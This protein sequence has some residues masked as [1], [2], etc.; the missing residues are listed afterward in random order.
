MARPGSRHGGPHRALARRPPAA[1]RT[2]P[3]CSG[4][5]TDLAV[6]T[7]NHSASARTIISTTAATITEMTAPSCTE[8]IWEWIDVPRSKVTIRTTH[9]VTAT[10]A[11][12]G[13]MTSNKM[14]EPTSVPAGPPR[15]P[16]CC[17]ADQAPVRWPPPAAGPTPFGRRDRPASDG[18]GMS[19]PADSVGK[20][21]TAV[22]PGAPVVNRSWSYPCRSA[23]PMPPSVGVLATS[24]VMIRA[25]TTI[26]AKKRIP[27]STAAH[28]LPLVAAMRVTLCQG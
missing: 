14:R 17:A 8:L 16:R 24:I 2:A 26:R 13:V 25:T 11:T 15:A 9:N 20:A 5:K 27:A 6:L 3:R 10:A 22:A 4:R 19:R 23:C 18:T 28:I 12:A 7:M 1:H 21:W